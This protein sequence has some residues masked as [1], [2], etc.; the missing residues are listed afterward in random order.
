MADYD[1]RNGGPRGGYN[2]RKRRYRE[3]DDYDRRPQRRRYEEPLHVKV[4]K[5]LLGIAESPLKRTDEEITEIAKIIVE[6]YEDEHIKGLYLDL[7]IQLVVEQPLKIPFIA[8]VVLAVNA[9]KPEL[10]REGLER[11]VAKIQECLHEG[12]WRE[13]KLVLRFLGCLQ[14]ILE[15]DGVFPIFEDLFSRAIR[16]QT[17][18]SE[19]TL[20]LELIKVILFSLPYVMA[21]TSAEQFKEQALAILDKTDIIASTPHDLCA[22]A[23]PYHGGDDRE[24]SKDP[25]STIGLIQK[26]LQAE[27]EQAWTLACIPR[28]WNP[29]EGFNA[30]D[31]TSAKHALPE[32]IIPTPVPVGSRP[33]LPDVY[34]S[35]YGDQ[36]IETVPPTSDIASSLVRDS[37]I[38]TI[39][40]LDYNRNITA[41]FL[42]DLDCYF[43]ENTFVKR[44]TQFDKLRTIEEGRSTWKPEDVIVDAV[45]SQLLQL[46]TPEHKLVYYHS[47]LTEACKIAPAAVAPSLGRAIRWLYQNVGTMDLELVYR[48]MDWFSHHLSNFGFTWKWTEWV[49]DVGLPMVHPKKAF[50][51]G[52]L[53]KEIR[54]SF[55]ARIRGTLPEPYRP[56]ITEAKEED[57]PPFKYSSDQTPYAEPAR[58]IHR[59]LKTRAPD[60]DLEA[61]INIIQESATNLGVAE[62]LIAS[63]DAYVTAI[64][65]LGS[66]SLSHVLSQ[67]ERC[68][69]RLLGIGLASET[70]RRQIITSVMEYWSEKPG[71]GVNV[72][73]KL[74]NYTILTPQ[75]VIEW[76]LRDCLGKGEILTLAHI[77]EMVAS[78]VS[79]VTNRVRQVVIARNAPGLPFDQRSMLDDTFDRERKE[80]DRL[81]TLIEDSLV[82]VAEGINDSMA[83][84]PDPDGTGEVMLREWG[85]RWLRVMRRKKGVE[86]SWILETMTVAQA[87]GAMEAIE[88]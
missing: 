17:D 55:A 58:E 41:K 13:V 35:V 39:N 86:E 82:G 14:G 79:K 36:E 12:T 87:D 29:M 22:L 38:D 53:E 46:P 8:G 71:V 2:S 48:F 66:K 37:L 7:S 77:Y 32:I 68:K 73:D 88:G 72:V 74:L 56:L 76:A 85:T 60:A 54:L 75:S 30:A 4:R 31:E 26:Q 34:F 6:H 45:F 47:V 24:E 61:P 33:R 27:A 40:I 62:P 18:S 44:A 3:D 84:G 70:A 81:F 57:T 20:G 43:A 52:A 10:A 21:T 69:D 15:G 49:D 63:T 65:Y 42:I 11:A 23:N 59:L 67:I 19:D 80:M 83:E 28:P 9:Q 78:T 51:V 5:Q 64:C 1:R 50:I 16:L 25:P